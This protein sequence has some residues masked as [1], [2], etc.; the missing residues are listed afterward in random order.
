[1]LLGAGQFLEA[2]KSFR[3]VW[4]RGRYG[5]GKSYMAFMVARHFSTLGYG[6]ISNIK[7]DIG[8]PRYAIDDD[9]S[10]NP[11]LRVGLDYYKNVI[12]YDE[13]GANS[14]GDGAKSSDIKAYL[15][16]LRKRDFILLVPSVLELDK[17]AFFIWCERSRPLTKLGIPLWIYEWGVK[18]YTKKQSGGSF[19]VFNPSAFFGS[20]DT[21]S[22][23]LDLEEL[24]G[25]NDRKSEGLRRG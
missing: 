11:H 10:V 2:C 7:N 3:S 13:G 16:Y 15:A 8:C 22:E 9:L 24:F 18:G 17:R 25:E 6:L 1:M 12:V 19:A 5:G 23:P 4:F 20:Y 14:L 21:Y